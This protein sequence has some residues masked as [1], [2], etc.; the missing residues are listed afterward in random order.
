MKQ[1]ALTVL[2]IW[3]RILEDVTQGKN[4]AQQ[5]FHWS[6]LKH[7]AFLLTWDAM[8]LLDLG[9]KHVKVD[10]TQVDVWDK[11][12]H[13]LVKVS[14]GNLTIDHLQHNTRYSVKTAALGNGRPVLTYNTFL[15]TGPSGEFFWDCIHCIPLYACVDISSREAHTYHA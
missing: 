3:C 1:D 9:A 10:Y 14:M 6:R 12:K 2:T 5:V 11:V 13:K 8:R 15:K 7:N 4:P